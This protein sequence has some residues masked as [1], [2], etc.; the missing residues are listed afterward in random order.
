MEI[1]KMLVFST[2]ELDRFQNGP[3]GITAPR[4]EQ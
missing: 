4:D 3:L 1:V 2:N